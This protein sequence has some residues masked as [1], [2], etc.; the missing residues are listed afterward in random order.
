MSVTMQALDVY[1]YSQ[2]KKKITT[3]STYQERNNILH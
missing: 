1:Q 3:G 2:K